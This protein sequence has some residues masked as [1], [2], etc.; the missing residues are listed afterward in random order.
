MVEFGVHEKPLSLKSGKPRMSIA[1]RCGGTQFGMLSLV[2]GIDRVRSDGKMIDRLAICECACGVQKEYQPYALKIGHHFSCGCQ[3]KRRD[4]LRKTIQELCGKTVAG[5]LTV[6]GEEDI[7]PENQG[8]G[9]QTRMAVCRC[10]CGNIVKR[11]PEHIKRGQFNSC[12]CKPKIPRGYNKRHGDSK[13]ITYSSWRGA[14]QRCNAKSGRH[15]ILYADRGIKVCERW[16]LYENFLEDMG[17]RPSSELTLDRIDPNGNYEP[18]NCQ[19]ANKKTQAANRRSTVWVDLD[20]EKYVTKDFAA[21]T[22][23]DP[24]LIS[25]MTKSGMTGRQIIEEVKGVL[26]SL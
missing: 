14:H 15:K 11:Q 5:Y 4:H 13:S 16:Y 9:H 12:G 23:I 17:H 1:E 8:K 10:V 3:P 21:I 19:W 25:K 22:R 2:G 7:A 18:S 24:A 6:I 20:G 26:A